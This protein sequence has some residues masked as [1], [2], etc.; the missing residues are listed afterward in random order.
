MSSRLHVYFLAA[1]FLLA[2]PVWA[3][4]YCSSMPVGQGSEEDRLMTAVNATDNAQQQLAALEAFAQAH[5]DSSYLPCVIEDIATVSFKAGD[6]DK[7][8]EFAEKD[9]AARYT[10]L[11]LY[12]TLMRA[13]ASSTKVSDTIFDVINKA[14]AQAKTEGAAAELAKDAHDYAIWDFFQLLPRVTDPAKQIPLIDA[15][16][17]AFPEED[18]SAQADSAYFQAYQRQRSWDK[19][20]EYGDKAIAADSG[21]AG[22]LN[23]LAM[24]EALYLPTPNPDKAID[25]AQKAL[26]AAQASKKPEGVDDAAFKSQQ[27]SQMGIAHMILG[28]A[29]LMKAQPATKFAPIFGEFQTASTLLEGN[30]ALQGQDLYYL[31]FAYERQKPANHKAAL[32]TLNKAV[33]LAGPFQAQSQ[34]LLEKVKAVAK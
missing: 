9:L 13:Y 19:A 11:T 27:N 33:T 3:Q 1:V 28:Y 8:I 15:F 21:N 17:K 2:A 25:Y 4:R 14:P 34:A 6:F 32:E 22:V 29:A 10:D 16:V 7:A 31:A 5:A 24:L 26:A 12:L 30:P 18:N 23:S 20:V